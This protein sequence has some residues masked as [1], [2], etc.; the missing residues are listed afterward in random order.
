MMNAEKRIVKDKI[1]IKIII[2]ILIAVP[3]MGRTEK[4]SIRFRASAHNFIETSNY[5]FAKA[6][7]QK[8]YRP[9]ELS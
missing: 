5:K 6:P 7:P 4:F 8:F 1:T 3:F 2:R 9:T